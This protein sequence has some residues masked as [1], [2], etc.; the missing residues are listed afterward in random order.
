MIHYKSAATIFVSAALL[1]VLYGC[2]NNNN[3]PA[4]KTTD[5]SSPA[6]SGKTINSTADFDTTEATSTSI[7]VTSSFVSGATEYNTATTAVSRSAPVSPQI[8]DSKT[9][10]ALPHED[11]YK[12]AGETVSGQLVQSFSCD[13]TYD[14][15]NEDIGK[16]YSQDK[17]KYFYRVYRKGKLLNTVIS[18]DN[19]SERS[20]ECTI[21]H[22][23]NTGEYHLAW[24]NIKNDA[25][26]VLEYLDLSDDSERSSTTVEF[27]KENDD[28]YIAGNKVSPE[29]CQQYLDNVTIVDGD[30]RELSSFLDVNASDSPTAVEHNTP[31][32]PQDTTS[33]PD[34]VQ[35]TTADNSGEIAEIREHYEK[36]ISEEQRII[37]SLKNDERYNA[38]LITASTEAF[39]GAI[40][41]KNAEKENLERSGNLEAAAEIQ[42]SINEL[43]WMIKQTEYSIGASADIARHEELKNQ[44]Q[45]EMNSRIAALQ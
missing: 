36:L 21:V 20:S 17:N 10:F 30:E 9:S 40:E 23:G 2:G 24:V 43:E 7:S 1:A 31:D 14:G 32:T 39:A 44:Y 27:S 15:A 13:L 16:Y 45:Q 12:H 29:K 26:V 41:A 11:S 35:P 3:R 4:P 6:V 34:I 5:A 38:S 8:P 22:D 19:N 37:D 28:T 42:A 33:A 18:P 25:S